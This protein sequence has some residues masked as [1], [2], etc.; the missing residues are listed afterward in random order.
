MTLPTP[1][2]DIQ[3]SNIASGLMPGANKLAVP[4]W[5]IAVN[6]EFDKFG[7]H[8]SLGRVVVDFSD[9]LFDNHTGDFDDA[10]G[11]F[12]AAA[13]AVQVVLSTTKEVTG[14][15]QLLRSTRNRRIVAGTLDK[16][17]HTDGGS[18]STSST[19]FTG[20]KDSAGAVRASRW[21]MVAFDDWTLATN[22][23]DD[24]Q[25]LKVGTWAALA[26]TTFD[27]AE[28]FR[29][30]GPYVIAVNTSNGL[31]L[32]EWCSDGDPEDWTPT[33]ANTAGN[34]PLSSLKTE[35]LAAEPIGPGLAIYSS[36]QLLQFLPQSTGSVFRLGSIVSGIGA[37]SK[38]SVVPAGAYH[39]GLMRQ[40]M[41]K[42]DGVSSEWVSYP[43]LGDWLERNVNWDQAAKICGYHNPALQQVCWAVPSMS[44]L[45]NDLELRY[46]YA[47]GAISRGNLPYTAAIE[48]SVFS[49]PL[50]GGYAGSVTFGQNGYSNKGLAITR[51]LQT[52]PLDFG[53][54][55]DWK[56]V[57]V[58]QSEIDI[59]S[60]SGPTISVG[61]QEELEDSNGAA[62][63]ITWDTPQ[64]LGRALK[65]TFH[66]VS[67][68][69]IS[70]KWE[71]T[72][73]DD[74]WNLSGFKIFGTRDGGSL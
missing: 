37:V 50:I 7:A 56:Y 59:V 46:N 64:A 35:P 60:G 13:E 70:V 6:V 71:S 1:L 23:V 21:S 62:V 57:D 42:T 68:V 63:A 55:T 73:V 40:G 16:L 43:A 72:T 53:A 49:W 30:V 65:Q 61:W 52:K 41:F 20:Y 28:I 51:T 18:I 36:D 9:N 26:N 15:T 32:A 44:S 24:A 11:L 39:F 31:N 14:L 33:A 27:W 48:K 19:T 22:G 25:V 74:N 5:E 69:F 66:T 3:P 45:D 10:S 4:I 38:N 58:V 17:Y 47:T 67:G 29:K 54:R 34:L 8:T 12:D 2:L